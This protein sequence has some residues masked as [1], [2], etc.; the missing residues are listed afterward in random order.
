LQELFAGKKVHPKDFPRHFHPVPRVPVGQF[1]RK[2]RLASAMIDLSDG[3]STDLGHICEESGVGAEVIA[4]QLPL[5]RVTKNK[6]RV[7]LHYALHGG[8]DY[9]LLFTAPRSK[10]VPDHI[11]GVSVS[12][13]GQVK[14]GEK[15]FLIKESG[16]R[17]ELKPKGWEHFR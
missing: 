9:E 12:L 10:R 16:S 13:I 8:D 7:D 1:L 15:A 5:A 6:A 14:R 3:L 17:E 2:Q 11:A 4:S